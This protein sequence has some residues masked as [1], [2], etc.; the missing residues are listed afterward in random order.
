[1]NVPDGG[2]AL[3]GGRSKEFRLITSLVEPETLHRW[4][5]RSCPSVFRGR[6]EIR[7]DHSI[8]EALFHH[9]CRSQALR[10]LEQKKGLVTRRAVGNL[11]LALKL[12][13]PLYFAG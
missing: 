11:S 9:A 3:R 2:A 12:P 10:L 6:R 1:M 4:T 13:C 5:R 7:V 8:G